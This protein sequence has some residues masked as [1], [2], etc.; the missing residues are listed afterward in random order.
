MFAMWLFWGFNPGCPKF[1]TSQFRKCISKPDGFSQQSYP[2]LGKPDGQLSVPQTN[3]PSQSL[4]V[5]QSPSSSLQGLLLLQ[6][7]QSAV[8]PWHFEP[9][10]N[11]L[12]TFWVLSGNYAYSKALRCMFFGEWKNSCSSNL[13]NLSSLIGLGQ[14]HQ[15][16][17]K[18]KFFTT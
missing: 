17:V 10:N 18:L 6:Q 11:Q 12:I 2:E 16:N 13:C 1:A 14:D 7:L 15:K 3:P 8:S 4:S 9:K 5:S